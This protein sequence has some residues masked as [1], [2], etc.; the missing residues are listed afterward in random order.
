MHKALKHGSDILVN[1]DGDNQ[2]PSKYIA[3]L[4]QPIVK[5]KADIVMGD[6]QTASIS[7]FSPL[8]KFFQWLGSLMVRVLSGTKVADSVS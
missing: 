2:Y 4:V 5:G 1:T 6:R 8:K 7:H 3:D